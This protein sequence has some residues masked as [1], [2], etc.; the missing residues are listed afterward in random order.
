[1][2][3]DFVLV[4]FFSC[5]AYMA[6]AFGL[7]K[8]WNIEQENGSMFDLVHVF[9]KRWNCVKLEKRNSEKEKSMSGSFFSCISARHKKELV[10]RSF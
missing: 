6:F 3:S 9:N 2:R 1:M 4:R 10:L 5:F 8:M 7:H